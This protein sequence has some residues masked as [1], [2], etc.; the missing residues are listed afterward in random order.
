MF[1]SP[2]WWVQPSEG[3]LSFCEWIKHCQITFD[4]WVC[5]QKWKGQLQIH[6][7][8]L[9]KC[10]WLCQPAELGCLQWSNH[11]GFYLFWRP[12]VPPFQCESDSPHIQSQW[13]DL[14]VITHKSSPLECQ[15]VWDHQWLPFS[16]AFW[17]W[18]V[19]FMSLLWFVLIV[20]IVCGFIVCY[21]NQLERLPRSHGKAL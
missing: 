10:Q 19:C 13:S 3:F 6:W 4:G 12:A 17:N 1:A 2:F 5:C 9:Q 14:H 20:L 7:S 16:F 21:E 18:L 8:S 15:E 11:C